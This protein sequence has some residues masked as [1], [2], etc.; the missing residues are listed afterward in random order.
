M[1]WVTESWATGFCCRG[2]EQSPAKENLLQTVFY[3][4]IELGRQLKP[5]ESWEKSGRA[6]CAA[7]VFEVQSVD[8]L[9]VDESKSGFDR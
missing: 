7:S 5:A 6:A 2:A 9:L 3:K 4:V 1:P 8:E